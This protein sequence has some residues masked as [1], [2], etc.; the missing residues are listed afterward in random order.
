MFSRFGRAWLMTSA[1][2]RL[3]VASAQAAHLHCPATIQRHE[4][5]LPYL[6]GLS[7]NCFVAYLRH[8][9]LFLCAAPRGNA[10]LNQIK[11]SLSPCSPVVLGVLRSNLLGESNRFALG[12]F[13]L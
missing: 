9:L 4:P 6:S 8:E 12:F 11:K 10:L 7:G 5:L 1:Q 3:T 2:R 13:R